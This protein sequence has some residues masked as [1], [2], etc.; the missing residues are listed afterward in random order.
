MLRILTAS[1]FASQ[2]LKA[3]KLIRTYGGKKSNRVS[4]ELEAGFQPERSHSSR[5]RNRHQ[6]LAREWP[7]TRHACVA[8]EDQREL[9]VLNLGVGVDSHRP[10]LLRA[11]LRAI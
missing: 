9:D 6:A 10:D 4:P 8:R 1:E 5:C 7:V 11:P 2:L 3:K